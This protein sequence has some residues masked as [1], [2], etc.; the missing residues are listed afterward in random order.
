MEVQEGKGL[1]RFIRD[2]DGS[3][4]GRWPNKDTGGRHPGWRAQQDQRPG[5]HP[6]ACGWSEGGECRSAV[7][8]ES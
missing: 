1:E 7:W 4:S 3:G 2:H 5:V 8:G 6:E